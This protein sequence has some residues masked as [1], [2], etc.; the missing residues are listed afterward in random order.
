MTRCVSLLA[1]MFDEN[2]AKLR[3]SFYVYLDGIP[4]FNKYSWTTSVT[5]PP[6]TLLF[7]SH[8]LF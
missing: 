4:L 6:P 5:N 3:A 8:L 1:E 2:E 7:F